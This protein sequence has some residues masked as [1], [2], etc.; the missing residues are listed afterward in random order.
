MEGIF[1][2]EAVRHLSQ[3]GIIKGSTVN[4]FEPHRPITR[5]EFMAMVVRI[6]GLKA[7]RV[8]DAFLLMS[9]RMIGSFLNSKQPGSS[10][11]SREKV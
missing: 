3:K 10:E 7:D 5:A 8:Y 4:T 2:K 1:S 9:V 11:L 6:T